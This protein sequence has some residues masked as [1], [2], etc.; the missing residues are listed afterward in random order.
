MKTP[1]IPCAA[2][3]FAENFTF[4][5]ARNRLQIFLVLIVLS[6]AVVLSALLPHA[7][8]KLTGGT[9]T[10][11]RTKK[12]GSKVK[13]RNNAFYLVGAPDTALNT[14]RKGHTA[15]LLS[16]GK[17]LVVGGENQNG[18]VAE[19][20]IFDPATGIFSFSGNLNIARA[21]H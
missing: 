3:I 5:F 16:D 11:N 18:F 8:A 15:T 21:D 6:G 10:R 1:F 17:V 12:S 14:A 9:T 7:R 20:E 2:R 19:V 13:F 4:A